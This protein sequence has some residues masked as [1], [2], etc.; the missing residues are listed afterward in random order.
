MAELAGG[1]SDRR[2][3]RI[4]DRIYFSYRRADEAT[5]SDAERGKAADP[6]KSLPGKLS[7]LGNESRPVFRKLMKES[8]EVAAAI[9]ILDKKIG[10]LAEALISKSMDGSGPA[11]SDV[12]LSASGVGFAAPAPL[13]RDL[14]VVVTMLLP[15]SLFKIVA[16]GKVVACRLNDE[17]PEAG[18]F[19]IGVDFT[20]IDERDQEF[21][22]GYVLKKQAE[23]IKHQRE[24]EANR[25]I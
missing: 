3:F 21:L 20:R 23:E 9:A 2:F 7:A 16:D 4:R 18:K 17:V 10:L 14:P 25:Y 22:T 13:P 11:M 5:P 1:V 19:W 6:L 15:P 24:L 12:S 8:P